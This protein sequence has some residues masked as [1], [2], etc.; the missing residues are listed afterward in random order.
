[1]N[2]LLLI[3]TVIAIY[4][5]S[6][7]QVRVLPGTNIRGLVQTISP[8]GTT[9]VPMGSALVTLFRLDSGS[10]NWVTV[11]RTTTNEYGYYFF[12]KVMPNKYYIQ[13]NGK[14]NYEITVLEIDR[15]QYRFQE[16]PVIVY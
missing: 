2:K 10:S 1:M 11:A 15:R 12:Y 14:K 9:K 16:L 8:D 13:V 4:C 3:L 5:T 6:P 7:A